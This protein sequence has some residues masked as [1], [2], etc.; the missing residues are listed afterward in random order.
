MNEGVQ[1]ERHRKDSN[2]SN[3]GSL[4]SSPFPYYYI[5]NIGLVLDWQ[6]GRDDKLIG[7]PVD[8]L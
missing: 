8:S 6:E 7:G 1:S 4:T 5:T 3:L 2:L